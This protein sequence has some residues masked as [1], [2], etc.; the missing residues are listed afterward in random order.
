MSIRS[1][2]THKR[3]GAAESG[4]SGR[5]AIFGEPVGSSDLA[6][7]CKLVRSYLRWELICVLLTS[8]AG[9]G[10]DAVHISLTAERGIEK[11]ADIARGTLGPETSWGSGSE[12][13]EGEDDELH[14]DGWCYWN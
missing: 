12:S 3:Q 4:K 1:P 9:Q 2:G 5:G 6:R 7:S 13:C 10:K 8:L 14:F 11:W